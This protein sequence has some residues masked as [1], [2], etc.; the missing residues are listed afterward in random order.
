MSLL[1][2]SSLA[3]DIIQQLHFSF[4]CVLEQASSKTLKYQI[5]PA[6][7]FPLKSRMGGLSPQQPG[8]SLG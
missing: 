1:F 4:F 7:H 3:A 5:L 2:E 6:D 8:P